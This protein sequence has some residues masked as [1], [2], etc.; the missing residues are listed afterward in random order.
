MKNKIVEVIIDNE[1]IA[2]GGQPWGGSLTVR[3]VR[4]NGTNRTYVTKKTGRA[5]HW[6]GM[7]VSVFEPNLSKIRQATVVSRRFTE[8]RNGE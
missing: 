7:I 2:Q 4:S 1:F 6:V 8:L 5:N 3:V